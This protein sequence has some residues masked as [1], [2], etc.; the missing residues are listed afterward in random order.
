[1]SGIKEEDWIH[2][3][4]LP[5]GTSAVPW[6]DQREQWAQENP[7]AKGMKFSEGKPR[8]QL[9]APLW[10]AMTEVVNVLTKGSIKYEDNNWQHVDRSE[11]IRAIMS[12]YTAYASGEQIDPDTDTHH[13]ANL[14]CSA[15]FLLWH[16]GIKR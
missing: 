12:H 11:Y 13:L 16:D 1:M 14:I 6:K 2:V 15:L 7:G 8:W 5:Q 9:M 4:D 3:E 10:P